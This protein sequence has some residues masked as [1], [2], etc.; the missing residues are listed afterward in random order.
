MYE[1]EVWVGGG[2][3]KGATS[4]LKYNRINQILQYCKQLKEGEGEGEGDGWRV[5]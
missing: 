3:R 5:S 2:G 1:R 4:G